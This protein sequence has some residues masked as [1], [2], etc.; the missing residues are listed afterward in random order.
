MMSVA[1]AGLGLAIGWALSHDPRLSLV[2]AARD[3]VF[4]EL[5]DGLFVLD[6][7]DRLV[8]LNRTA[9]RILGRNA[10]RVRGATAAE[11]F[12]G[13]L[14]SCLGPVV[15]QGSTAEIGLGQ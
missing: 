10:A 3:A 2:A 9:E 5:R 15:A 11:V 13:Q 8:D 12:T 6:A 1:L 7:Q 14:Q 4:A